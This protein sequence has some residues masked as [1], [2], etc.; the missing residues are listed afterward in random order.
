MGDITD[1]KYEEGK[2][3][4]E[5][6]KGKDGDLIRYY[7][8]SKDKYMKKLNEEIEEMMSIF[9]GISKYVNR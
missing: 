3:L 9:D 6:L 1:N 2:K 7:V 8:D 5:G 4:L